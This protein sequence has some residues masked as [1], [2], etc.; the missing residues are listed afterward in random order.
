ME[1]TEASQGKAAAKW[2]EAE[3]YALLLQIIKQLG[4][5]RASIKFADISLPGRTPKAL[6]LAWQKIKTEVAALGDGNGAPPAAVA[7]PRKRAANK[8]KLLLL[9]S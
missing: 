4:G 8:G 9:S 2:T 3:K 5:E 6:S 7:T 1:D